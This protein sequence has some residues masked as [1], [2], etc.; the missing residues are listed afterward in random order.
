MCRYYFPSFFCIRR[1]RIRTKET[2]IATTR[3][4]MRIEEPREPFR[5]NISCNS[6][7]IVERTRRGKRASRLDWRIRNDVPP[8]RDRKIR[9]SFST[10]V[11]VTS[12]R[13]DRRFEEEEEEEEEDETMSFRFRDV[14][15]V[16]YSCDRFST[17]RVNASRTMIFRRRVF[18]PFRSP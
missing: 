11:C 13:H 15:V 3:H 5:K 2:T 12:I 4:A 9:V 7:A 10:I 18:L 8:Y 14:L 6:T 16:F 1:L 17:I